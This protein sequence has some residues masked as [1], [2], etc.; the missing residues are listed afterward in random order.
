MSWNC[1]PSI[2]QMNRESVMNVVIMGQDIPMLSN[3]RSR[4]EC[5]GMESKGRRKSWSAVMKQRTGERK[6]K[7]TIKGEK[8]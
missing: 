6:R 2:N 5:D 4:E 7:K 3:G 1:S 8:K